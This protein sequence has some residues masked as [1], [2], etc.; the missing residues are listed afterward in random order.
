MATVKS[1]SGAVRLKDVS[2]F[3]A[4]SQACVVSLEPKKDGGEGEGELVRLQS[5]AGSSAARGPSTSQPAS[6]ASPVKVTLNDCLACSGCVT[7]A[8]TVLLEQQSTEEF[9]RVL[10]TKAE[11]KRVV[12]VTLSSQSRTSLAAHYG[13]SPLETTSRLCGF[14]K[15]LGVD[16]VLEDNLGRDLALLATLEEFWDK[17]ENGAADTLPL[18]TSECPG[19]VLYAEK[20]HGKLVLPHMSKA[21]SAVATLGSLCK[22]ALPANLGVDPG[23][24]YHCFISPCFD[25]KLEASR[26]DLKSGEFADLDCVLAT[27]E[28]HKLLEAKSFDSQ[29]GPTAPFDDIFQGSGTQRTQFSARGSSGGYLE[30][31]FREC[32]LRLKGRDLFPRDQPLPLKVVRNQDFQEISLLADDGKILLSF[33]LAYGF[34]NI[35][36]IIRRIKQKKMTYHFVEVMACPSGCLNGGGQMKDEGAR[37]IDRKEIVA[38]LEQLYHHGEV[39]LRDPRGNPNLGQVE[40]WLGGFTSQKATE[41]LHTTFHDRT[42][43]TETAS[44][45]MMIDF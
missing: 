37:V 27:T 15:S 11:T 5:R 21:R 14:L 8:E 38:Q 22:G 1:F 34:R 3:I 39:V 42:Q 25:K 31:V 7:S 10:D 35:Q 16:L 45:A 29:G 12:V 19:W 40:A 17:Y 36:N 43:K 33:A 6:E 20:T 24:I 41:V 26:E 9:L 4:P 18:L 13:L 23:R 2:D 32:V 30:F 44:T 28:F